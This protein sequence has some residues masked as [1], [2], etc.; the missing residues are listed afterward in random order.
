MES[1]M[2]TRKVAMV[3]HWGVGKTSLVRQFVSQQFGEKYLATLGVKIDKKVVELDDETV[4][5][6]LWD[7]AGS[8]DDFSVPMH[9]VKGAAGYLLV[10]DQ[11]RPDTLLSAKDLATAIGKEAP[12]MKCVVALNKSDLDAEISPDDLANAKLADDWF[13]TSAKTGDGVEEAFAALARKLIA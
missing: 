7:I 3:G 9:Y 10:V 2:I 8:E 1:D 13:H 4:N 11:T 12:D 5:I 6:V